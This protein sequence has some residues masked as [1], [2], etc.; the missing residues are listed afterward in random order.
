MATKKL[1]PNDLINFRTKHGISAQ[2]FGELLYPEMSA[3]AVTQKISKWEKG[4]GEIPHYMNATLKGL[5]LDF[6]EKKSKK[7]DSKDGDH[8]FKFIDLFAG[9]GGMRLPF[10]ELGG[11]C[12]FT[13]EWDAYP[14]KVYADNYGDK[15]AGDIT[16]VDAANIPAHDILLA[17]FPCQPF[18]IA[19]VSKKK[20]LGRE[21]GF[22]DKTQ[23]TLFFDVARI[24]EHHRPKMFLL[25]NVKN[26]LSHDKGNTFKVIIDTLTND[27]GYN[28]SYQIVDAKDFVPQHRERIYIVGV[29][30]K[31]RN[32][33]FPDVI[34]ASH[35]LGDILEKDSS[36]DPKYTLSDRLWTGLQRHAQKHK[37]KGNGF[38]FGLVNRSGIARTLSARYYKDGSEILI[39]Q[40]NKN[41]RRL[42]PR[43]CAR[44]MGFP[45]TFEITVSDTRAYKC[46][47]NS[48]VVPVI[49]HLAEEIVSTLG[50]MKHKKTKSAKQLTFNDDLVEA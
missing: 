47:G 34:K 26:L 3:K 44:L 39:E 31:E 45:E 10:E 46:F 5:D 9:I 20:S 14:A 17:G 33:K 32:F 24:I 42:T 12:V 35:K 27:L 16:K 30:S 8:N 50:A 2:E 48:V 11:D 1:T 23:G 38:G 6:S 15:P 4:E 37:A 13:S 7:K 18:S 21:H 41:P 49:R 25:E 19:G 22:K 40:K 43:E 36:V 28:V 29:D